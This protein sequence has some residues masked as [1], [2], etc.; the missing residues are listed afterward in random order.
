MKRCFSDSILTVPFLMG[1][2]RWKHLEEISESDVE[3]IAFWP[4][5]HL[6][7]KETMPG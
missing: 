4:P 3:Y 7:V 5:D 1:A 6:M 2:G